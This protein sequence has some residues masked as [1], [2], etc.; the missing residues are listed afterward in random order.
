VCATGRGDTCVGDEM[1]GKVA[2]A[3]AKDQEEITEAVRD[4]EARV[5]AAC[6]QHEELFK[7]E[8]MNPVGPRKG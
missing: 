1:G 3:I 2:V 4:R 5:D 8:V 6:V 7:K